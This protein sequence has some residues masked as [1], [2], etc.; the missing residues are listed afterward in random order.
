MEYRYYQKTKTLYSLFFSVQNA[1]V[2]KT[3][4][5]SPEILVMFFFYFLN[6]PLK[7]QTIT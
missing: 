1:S 4:S 2:L 5:L 7:V 3:K 6:Q